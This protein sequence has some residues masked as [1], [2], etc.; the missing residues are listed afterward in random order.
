[1]SAKR[2]SASSAQKMAEGLREVELEASPLRQLLGRLRA[3]VGPERDQR[4]GPPFG[5]VV[6]PRSLRCC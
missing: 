4:L 1:M 5:S 6:R 2:R 3:V